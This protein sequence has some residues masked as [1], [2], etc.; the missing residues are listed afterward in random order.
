MKPVALIQSLMLLV[1][2][3]ASAESLS[4]TRLPDLPDREGFAG[5]FAGASGDA[6]IVAGG[7]N[8]PDKRPWEGGTKIWRDEIWLLSSPKADWKIIGR[9]PRP[10]AYGISVTF[11]EEI[12]CVGGSNAEGHHADCFALRFRDGK[13]FRREL[14]PLPSP[15]ANHC[16]AVVDGTLFA[17][18]GIGNA[19]A[20]TAMH[21]FWS[22]DLREDDAKWALLQPWP[23]KERMLAVA[24]SL[25]GAFYLFGGAALHAG[26]DGKPAREWMNDAYR[27]TAARG[28][29]KLPMMPRVVVAAAS[30]APVS[31]SALFLLSGDDGSKAGFKPEI[32]HPGFPRQALRFEA[33]EGRWFDAGPVPFSRATVPTAWWR[34]R[35]VIP[36]GEARPGYRTN[37][38]WQL[39]LR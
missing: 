11:Q 21:N 32:E 7:A 14:P 37:E 36:S 24:G 27:F 20:T 30:P 35:F 39:D 26:D 18:G 38:V 2:S 19:D 15:C 10:L 8:F 5:M 22:L 9:L 16:G 33:R 17:A 29:E 13:L 23:G 25:N 34:G 6:L 1:L 28:W 3:T 31:S 4:F 12:I